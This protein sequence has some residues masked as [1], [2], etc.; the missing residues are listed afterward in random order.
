MTSLTCRDFTGSHQSGSEDQVSADQVTLHLLSS[1]CRLFQQVEHPVTEMVTGLDLVEWQLR[2]ASGEPLPL[3]QEQI[4]LLGH[5]VEARLYAGA[6]QIIHLPSKNSRLLHCV[7]QL[8]NVRVCFEAATHM[9][10]YVSH[11]LSTCRVIHAVRPSVWLD[12][13]RLAAV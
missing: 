9:A 10:C 5:A 4:P 3:T 12:V 7:A 2:V 11:R 8:C 13:S 6:S 1:S